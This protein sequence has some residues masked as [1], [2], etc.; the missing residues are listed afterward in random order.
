[1]ELKYYKSP[2]YPGT[3]YELRIDDF[4]LVNLN[5]TQL[6]MFHEHPQESVSEQLYALAVLVR[7]LEEKEYERK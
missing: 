2:Y 1:M 6:K 7:M 3:I 5:S 4:D